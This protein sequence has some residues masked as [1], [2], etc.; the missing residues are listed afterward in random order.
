MLVGKG[1]VC[2]EL[3]KGFNVYGDAR[4]MT[5]VKLGQHFAG[6]MRATDFLRICTPGEVRA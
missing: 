5:H 2:G 3:I 6:H 4:K 1:R